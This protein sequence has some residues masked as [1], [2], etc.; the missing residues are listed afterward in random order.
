MT[1]RRGDKPAMRLKGGRKPSL[2]SL[3]GLPAL[4]L[5]GEAA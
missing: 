1:K 4:R 3:W 5:D 2:F